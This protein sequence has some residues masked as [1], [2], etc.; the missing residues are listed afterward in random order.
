MSEPQHYDADGSD[1]G[2]GDDEFDPDACP[3]CGNELMGDDW[4][5][6]CGWMD[7]EEEEA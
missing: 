4:C 6:A 7:E 5:P 1:V 2:P 3:D